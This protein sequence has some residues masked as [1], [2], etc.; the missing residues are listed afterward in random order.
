MPCLNIFGMI[1]QETKIQQDVTFAKK[2]GG[3][4]NEVHDFKDCKPKREYLEVW[5]IQTSERTAT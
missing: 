1:Y 2:K 5:L 4:N 3:K